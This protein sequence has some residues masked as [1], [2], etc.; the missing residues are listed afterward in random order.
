MNC[1]YRNCGETL[2]PYQNGKRRYCS[3]K[4]YLAE[5]L[6]RS[7]QKRD[8]TSGRKNKVYYL[9]AG[10]LKYLQ[11]KLVNPISNNFKFNNNEM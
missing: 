3:S 8:L 11:L 7:T 1:N 6:E 9:L 4:C 2:S 10:F 5:K